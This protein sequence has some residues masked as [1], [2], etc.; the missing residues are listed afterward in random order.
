[1][2]HQARKGNG[3]D[4]PPAGGHVTEDLVAGGFNSGEELQTDGVKVKGM[5]LS[6]C[7]V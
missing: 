5:E 3:M 1:M 4:V 6:T 7:K 2:E